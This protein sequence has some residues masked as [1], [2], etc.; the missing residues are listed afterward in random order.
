MR[1]H[2][3]ELELFPGDVKKA[4][5]SDELPSGF[6][7][8]QEFLSGKEESGLLENF[9][10]LNFNSFKFQ[11][12]VAKRRIVEYGFEYDF[13]T[14][15][16]STTKALPEF[17]NDLREKAAKWAGVATHEIVEAVI[18]EYPP[19]API[20]GTGTYGNLTSSSEYL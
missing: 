6:Q 18:T 19:G 4:L 7:Y 3:P 2:V 13:T 10:T 15:Q 17:L 9:Q 20:S 16:A 14:R 12:Y 5:E 11:G 1:K 8:E